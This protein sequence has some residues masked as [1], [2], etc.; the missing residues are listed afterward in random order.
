MTNYNE[1]LDEILYQLDDLTDVQHIKLRQQILQ[2]VSETV[3]GDFEW[4]L[5]ARPP[6]IR[7]QLRA[8]QREILR[9]EKRRWAK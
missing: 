2:W 3:V 7:N 6:F 5:K 4:T 1:R 9:K 8:E